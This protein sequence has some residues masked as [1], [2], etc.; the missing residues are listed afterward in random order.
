MPR[1]YPICLDM[2]RLPCLVVGGGSVGL[3]KVQVLLEVGARV[4]VVAPEAAPELRALADEGRIELAQRPYAESDLE[5]IRL[6]FVATNDNELN[7]R[8]TDEARERG[9]LINVVDVPE[10]CDFIVPAI[11]RRGSLLVAVSTEGACPAYA[12]RLRRRLE[13]EFDAAYGEYVDLLRRM[14][15]EILARTEHSSQAAR[16]LER[17]LDSDLF[18]VLRHEGRSAAEARARDLLKEV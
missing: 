2:T 6:A 4:R 5:G 9:I 1:Y 16:L 8:I 7:R 14:R 15:Q 10:L 12:K 11:V 17:L 18:E 13:L 3:R